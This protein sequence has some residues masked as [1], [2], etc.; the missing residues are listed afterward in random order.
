MPPSDEL[1]QGDAVVG[2]PPGICRIVT[3]AAFHF[4]DV[5]KRG[6]ERS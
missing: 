5:G 6:L 2:R 1:S 4:E 3:V